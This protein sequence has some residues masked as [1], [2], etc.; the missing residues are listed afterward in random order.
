MQKLANH[1]GMT[2]IRVENFAAEPVGLWSDWLL[3]TANAEFLALDEIQSAIEESVLGDPDMP[4][5]TD[6]YS[7]LFRLLDF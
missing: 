2:A 3:A 5:W 7:S 4:M 6:D 1:I